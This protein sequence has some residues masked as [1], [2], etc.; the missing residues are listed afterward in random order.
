MSAIDLDAL[1]AG[2]TP[3]SDEERGLAS[4]IAELRA[5]P[6]RAPERLR[7][8]VAELRP[9]RRTF[10]LPRPRRALFVLVPAAAVLAVAAAA[11]HG[12]R[13]GRPTQVQH[14]AAAVAATP[15]V[16]S[17]SKRKAFSQPLEATS[18]GVAAAP[19][20]AGGR[21]QRY[22][23]SITIRVG[24]NR[25]LSAATTNATR[26][27]RS[28][29]G[30]AASV[31]YRTPQ[32]RPGQAYL[33]L[34]IPTDRVQ[35]ALERLSSLGT[36]VQQRVSVQDLQ[37]DLEVEAAQIAQL[38]R[39]VR[40][41]VEALKSPTVTPLQRV[42]LRLRLGE[43]RRA[44]A[45]RTHAQRSTVAAGTL[46]RVS[47]VLTETRPAAAAPHRQRRLHRMLGSAVSF[48][49]LEATILLYGLIVIAPLAALAALAWSG[50]AFRRRRDERRLLSAPN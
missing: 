35:A 21:L 18:G 48:L 29:G 46:A 30:Y 14:G 1:L 5:A 43:A 15:A 28:L 11:V 19:P 44:L 20:P 41:L 22:E 24:A 6:P 25:D 8:R 9:A 39:E 31:V 7:E 37:H 34:R 49:G 33:E 26:I 17:G 2:G 3:V 32:G 50:L 27:A 40:L 42:E 4:V 23:A 47:L 12:V 13:S 38:R 36:L 45:Q 10:E 16:G